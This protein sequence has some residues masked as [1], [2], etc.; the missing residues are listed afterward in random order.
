M[1][2]LLLLFCFVPVL[3]YAQKQGFKAGLFAGITATQVDGDTKVGYNKPGAQFGMFI[4]YDFSAKTGFE[5]GLKFIQKGSRKVAHPDKGD[6]DYYKLSLNYTEIPVLFRYYFKK[7]IVAEAGIG[8]G[9][10]ISAK[11]D[12]DGYGGGDPFPEFKN[13]EFCPLVGVHF[14]V[15]EK[16]TA[17]FNFSYS[18][19][20]VRDFPGAASYH[21]DR[22]QYNNV[23]GFSLYYHFYK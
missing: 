11:E 4:R 23:I 3:L 2:W 14:Q 5:S 18:L 13:Y 21:F 1:R 7:G 22:D 6:L 10:L 12:V 16:L 20:P 9:Y 19:L 15:F 8:I 17:H